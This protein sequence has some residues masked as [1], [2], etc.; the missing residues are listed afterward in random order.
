[1][2]LHELSRAAAQPRYAEAAQRW[3]LAVWRWARDPPP[4]LGRPQLM[5]TPPKE[6][7]A[8][9]LMAVVVA[10]Q[11]ERRG[12]GGGGAQ[13]GGGDP[14]TG[15]G[16]TTMGGGRRNAVTPKWSSWRSG[17]REG[18]WRTCR[19]GTRR[20]WRTSAPMMRSCRALW[21]GCRT[22]GTP[23]KRVGCCCATPNPAAIPHW[24]PAS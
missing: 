2:G 13:I 23:W 1:M 20:C 5:G 16:P 24:L 15:G 19:G 4:A 11:N 7:L 22:Q 18:C 17:G 3:A 12:G 21:G 10:Q 6:E 14:T 8:V 9:P